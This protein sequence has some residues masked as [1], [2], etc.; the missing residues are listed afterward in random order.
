MSQV[1]A[2][3]YLEVLDLLKHLKST[4]PVIDDKLKYREWEKYSDPQEIEKIRI[5]YQNSID[6]YYKRIF[7]LYQSDGY[8]IISNI[9]LLE[10]PDSFIDVVSK[11][12]IRKV[13]EYHDEIENL[14]RK[15]DK[16]IQVRLSGDETIRK[17]NQERNQKQ[18]EE[19]DRIGLTEQRAKIS[20][21]EKELRSGLYSIRTIAEIVNRIHN[22]GL[23]CVQFKIAK[24]RTYKFMQLSCKTCAKNHEFICEC[25]SEMM[26][27]L[28]NYSWKDT[29][30]FDIQKTINDPLIDNEKFYEIKYDFISDTIDVKLVE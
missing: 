1:T 18:K 12:K 11:D 8:C 22:N 3:R 13:K 27:R 17:R 19:E 25:G 6:D 20:E 21:L 24:G 2:D 23:K 16:T 28:M 15:C 14:R 9:S 26:C 10:Y 7:Q 29:F 5:G 4:L 30:T